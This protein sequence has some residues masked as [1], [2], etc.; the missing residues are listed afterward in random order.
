MPTS[1]DHEYNFTHPCLKVC[2][3]VVFLIKQYS[4]DGEYLSYTLLV[5]NALAAENQ[6]LFCFHLERRGKGSS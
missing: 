3:M 4:E 1:W 5:S 2:N 6:E